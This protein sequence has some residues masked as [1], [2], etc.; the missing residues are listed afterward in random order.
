LKRFFKKSFK[1]NFFKKNLKKNCEK[2]LRKNCRKNFQKIYFSKYFGFCKQIFLK[3][4]LREKFL[5]KYIFQKKF[6]VPFFSATLLEV[7]SNGLKLE[8]NEIFLLH[9]IEVR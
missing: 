1:K 2:N 9:W 8:E 5:K 7:S 4:N 3:K 6:E